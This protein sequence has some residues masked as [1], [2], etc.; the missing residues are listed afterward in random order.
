MQGGVA[1][2]VHSPDSSGKS[3]YPARTSSVSVE[4]GPHGD[5]SS[6]EG[7]PRSVGA[8][9]RPP[10]L[11]PP[12]LKPVD[13]CDEL[14]IISWAMVMSDS[15]LTVAGGAR[16]RQILQIIGSAVC[17]RDDVLDGSRSQK[18][19]VVAHKQVAVAVYAFPCPRKAAVILDLLKRPVR[20][21]N[22]ENALLPGAR[23]GHR[24]D[25]VHA[26]KTRRVSVLLAAADM[27]SCV[28]WRA[29][30]ALSLYRSPGTSNKRG[31]RCGGGGRQMVRWT[32]PCPVLAS[33]GADRVADPVG[34][35][36]GPRGGTQG[37]LGRARAGK[38]LDGNRQYTPGTA[39]C[40]TP[41]SRQLTDRKFT[42]DPA[43]GSVPSEPKVKPSEL[44]APVGDARRRSSISPSRQLRRGAASHSPEQ[45][46]VDLDRCSAGE[47][48][49]DLIC[50]LA[51]AL[52]ASSSGARGRALHRR[53]RAR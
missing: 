10:P 52:V 50:G 11:S 43:L 17:L 22:R 49:G 8:S 16:E 2:C 29:S 1:R 45:P 28:P 30:A 23:R 44:A 20:R 36:R 39:R 31:E 6:V 25:G 47:I 9:P 48:P 53:W 41:A 51:A 18:R 15:L 5:R 40:T 14:W 27:H 21:D 19:P 34:F 12:A 42:P 38:E 37:T 32:Y 26:T 3:R 24:H 13:H 46:S 33:L 4:T 7:R 35:P